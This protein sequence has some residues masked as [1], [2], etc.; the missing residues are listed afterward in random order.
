MFRFPV[1]LLLVGWLTL[2]DTPLARCEPPPQPR[3][4]S[5][6]DPLPKGALA[7][8]GTVR[9]RHDNSITSLAF[10]PNGKTVASAG[11]DE[12]IRLWEVAT[13]KDLGQFQGSEK[14]NMSVAFSPDG[15]TLAS[16]GVD[17]IIRL[18]ELA[19]GKELVSHRGHR[20]S[21]FH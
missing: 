3:L 5:Y 19:G 7:R 16:G 12:T 13:G 15:K 20:S 8:A 1:C 9:F 2:T 11:G 6:G 17:E 10:A 14:G 21:Y 4:D 18:W